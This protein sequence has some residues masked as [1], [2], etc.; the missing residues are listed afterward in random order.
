MITIER[1]GRSVSGGRLWHVFCDGDLVGHVVELSVSEPMFGSGAPL[2]AV[3]AD[4]ANPGSYE[5]VS[6]WSEV[7]SYFNQ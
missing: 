1:K 5:L 2:Y 7:P 3:H 4:R 6:D